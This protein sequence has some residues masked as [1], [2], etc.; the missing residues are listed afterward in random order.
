MVPKASLPSILVFLLSLQLSIIQETI[1]L[2]YHFTETMLTGNLQKVT[3]ADV[4]QAATTD[5]RSALLVYANEKAISYES[6]DLPS[7][8]LV[9]LY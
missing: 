5:S 4:L 1:D 2:R 8:L 9:R 6:G 3:Q 7:P